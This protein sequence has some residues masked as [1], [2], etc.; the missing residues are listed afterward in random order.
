MPY[1]FAEKKISENQYLRL[2]QKGSTVNIKGFKTDAGTVEGLI[3][4]EENFKLK[5]EPKK[6]APKAKPS[7]IRCIN[8]S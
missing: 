1:T 7:N 6:T 5:L 2:V 4:F 3:R 8:M